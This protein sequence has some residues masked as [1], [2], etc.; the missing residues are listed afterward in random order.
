MKR[1]EFEI[2]KKG[3]EEDITRNLN[4]S[5]EKIEA[6]YKNKKY[7]GTKKMV[8]DASET[9]KNDKNNDV[10]KKERSITMAAEKFHFGELG[11]D[12]YDKLSRKENEA[13]LAF[14]RAA[15]VKKDSPEYL[16]NLEIESLPESLK[17]FPKDRPKNRNP[18]D[19]ID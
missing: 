3:L 15:L 8:K 7:V 10:E 18:K 13:K 2:I 17:E 12:H 4:K 1:E 5:K 14:K 19:I 11:M 6:F 9:D 16:Q